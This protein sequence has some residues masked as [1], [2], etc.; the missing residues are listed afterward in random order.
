MCVDDHT[1]YS[2]HGLNIDSS[3]HL[4][5]VIPWQRNAFKKSLCHFRSNDSVVIH[6]HGYMKVIYISVILRE[7][8]VYTHS[9]RYFDASTITILSTAQ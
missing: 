3:V 1:L 4:F 5:K 2:Y 6:E 7:I 8:S 9:F